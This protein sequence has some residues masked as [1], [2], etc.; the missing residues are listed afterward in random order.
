MSDHTSSTQPS[1]TD[2]GSDLPPLEVLL[3]EEWN[4]RGKNL[5][6]TKKPDGRRGSNEDPR[7]FGGSSSSSSAKR[8]SIDQS[9]PNQSMKMTSQDQRRSS[10]NSMD[11]NSE[12]P[13][14]K[15]EV[16]NNTSIPPL[17][18]I[19]VAI[20]VPLA[21]PQA[22]LSPPAV[23]PDTPPYFLEKLERL[24]AHEAAVRNNIEA[25]YGL[26]YL[27]VRA[28]AATAYADDD[29]SF[30]YFGATAAV[31][32]A[33]EAALRQDLDMMLENMRKPDPGPGPLNL[34]GNSPKKDMAPLPSMD[35]VDITYHP[36][37]SPREAAA[38]D[39]L[40]LLG[41]AATE[42][43]SFDNHVQAISDGIKWEMQGAAARGMREK[44]DRMDTD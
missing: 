17:N 41:A 36:L 1:P 42:L 29:A 39:V 35:V 27:R 22:L 25:L 34:A 12:P 21:N 32:P 40:R 13:S 8:R 4:N 7:G 16:G 14:G 30:D 11:N 2:S 10:T 20:F 26:E 38:N 37:N 43:G 3:R 15:G 44:Q 6:A 19:A 31:Q 24:G 18:N 28:K 9:S 33:Q 23:V 5:E